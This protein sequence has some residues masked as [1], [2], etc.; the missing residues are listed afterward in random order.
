MK[1]RLDYAKIAPEATKIM[2]QMEKY[3]SNT[4]IDKELTELIKIRTSQI[5]GCAFCLNMHTQDA[6]KIGMSNQR[7]D[8]VAAYFDAEVYTEKEKTA[9]ELAEYMTLIAD[10]H[11]PDELY[12]RVR[13]HFDEK[14]YVDLLFIINQINSWNRLSIATGNFASKEN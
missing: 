14:D 8:C 10:N 1:K 4:N 11:V 2:I 6:R 3:L 5:N 13:E 9:L 7:I 12:N